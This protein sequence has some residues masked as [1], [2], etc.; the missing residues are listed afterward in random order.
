MSFIKRNIGMIIMLSLAVVLLSGGGKLISFGIDYGVQS[1]RNVTLV[2]TRSSTYKHKQNTYYNTTG[3]FVDDLTGQ[4]F[5]HSI[6]DK[7]YREFEAGGNKPI[8][9]QLNLSQSALDNNGDPSFWTMLGGL[10]MLVGIL[11]VLGCGLSWYFSNK[12]ST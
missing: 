2:D 3:F 4:Q 8:Q 11:I 12:K 7:L 1:V 6:R 5:Y 10:L 9:T